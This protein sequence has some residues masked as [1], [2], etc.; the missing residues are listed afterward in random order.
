MFLFGKRLHHIEYG[1][2]LIIKYEGWFFFLTENAFTTARSKESDVYSYG[3]VLLELITGRKALDPS[4]TEETEIVEWVRSVWRS[5]RDIERIADSRLVD[6][7]VELEMRVKEQLIHVFLVALSCTEKEP[8]KRPTMR[9]V[10]RQLLNA[11]VT[12]KTKHY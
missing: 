10:V 7:F 1:W 4:F 2:M 9:D 8:S 12:H 11:N 6:E 3:V 5:T